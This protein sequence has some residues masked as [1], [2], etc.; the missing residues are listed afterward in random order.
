MTAC[1]RTLSDFKLSRTR[2]LKAS[3]LTSILFV[4][5]KYPADAACVISCG[6]EKVIAL[7]VQRKTGNQPYTMS[8]QPERSEN[9][10][11]QTVKLSLS[12]LGNNK[13]TWWRRTSISIRLIF[14]WKLCWTMG[15]GPLCPA[16]FHH[17]SLWY[18][19]YSSLYRG[20]ISLSIIQKYF[21]E[22]KIR[23]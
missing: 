1:T 21:L 15:I 17:L 14:A 10:W 11:D 19:C 12:R 8:H 22:A 7:A 20:D 6:C 4:G 2:F 3:A 13:N 5:F 18:F 23:I 16:S 9:R